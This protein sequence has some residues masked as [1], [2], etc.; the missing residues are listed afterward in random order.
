MSYKGSSGLV[1]TFWRLVVLYFAINLIVSSQTARWAEPQ[2][3]SAAV[4]GWKSFYR[5]SEAEQ[6]D[7]PAS[8]LQKQNAV[9][10]PENSALTHHIYLPL[11]EKSDPPPSSADWQPSFPIRAAFYYPWFPQTWGQGSN[12]PYTNYTPTLG[13]YSSSDPTLLKKHMAMLQ[14]AHIQVGIASWWGQGSTTDSN[15]SGLLAASAGTKFRWSLYYENESIGNPSAS[16]IQSDLIYIRDHYGSD[17][18]FLRINGKFVVFVYSD[19]GD[20]CGMADRWKQANTVGAYVVL[21][22]FPGFGSCASQPD[23]WHQYCP[24][25]PADHQGSISYSISPGFWQKGY[26]VR[27]GRDINRW[28]QNVRDMVASGAQWQLITTFNEWGEGT[29]VESASEWASPSGSGLYLD[30]L[31][32]NGQPASP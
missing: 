15:I 10:R 13:Y 24:A 5:L 22:V 29:A 12:F 21:K 23:S 14:Y 3:E 8:S 17:P 2:T 6:I 1:K 18:N 31:H 11:V 26:S 28:N 16:Q 27:L 30:A 19:G 7:L 9:G 25:V 32:N 4:P 20:S